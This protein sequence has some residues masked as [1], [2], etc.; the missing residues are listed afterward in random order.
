MECPECGYKTKLGV[1]RERS[2]KKYYRIGYS[3]YCQNA[4]CD[5]CSG[6]IEQPPT[7]RD[8]KLNEINRNKS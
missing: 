8:L 1:V 2:D 4:D 5:W 7:P 3:R 6:K